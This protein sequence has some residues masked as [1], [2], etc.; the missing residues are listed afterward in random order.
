MSP[1]ILYRISKFYPSFCTN[2]LALNSVT[3]LSGNTFISVSVWLSEVRKR[4]SFLL[5]MI[6][7]FGSI[8]CFSYFIGEKDSTSLEV[9]K[10]AHYL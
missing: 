8:R 1:Q 5:Q 6:D 9:S 2:R 3:C 7:V 10:M 4:R